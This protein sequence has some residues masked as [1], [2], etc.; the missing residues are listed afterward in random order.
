[1]NGESLPGWYPDPL[2][3][4]EFRYWDGA[5]W[6]HHVASGGRQSVDPPG[7]SEPQTADRGSKQ[8]RRDVRKAGVVVGQRVGG[9]TPFTEPV[10]VVHQKPKLVEI[11]AEYEV[12]DQ[13]G[14]KI[15]AVREV[16]QS[17]L[18]SA[19]LVRARPNRKRRLQIVDLSGDVLLVLT[20]PANILKSK[21]IVQRPAGEVVGEIVQTKIGVIGNVRFD[22]E[23]AGSRLGSISGE[24][25][26]TWDFNVQDAAGQEIARISKSRSGKA[27]MLLRDDKRDKYVV[28]IHKSLD[29]PL[30]SLVVASA[31]AVDTALRQ[32]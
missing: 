26:Q 20:R 21:V 5:T 2:G 12:F 3:R 4:H 13:H 19:A 22:L 18:R 6:T 8:V 9:R 14:H 15:G 7:E 29:E 32:G 10:L 31:L 28:E 16:G 11:N 27:A 24:G 23:S 1:M 17:F 30:L 25:W